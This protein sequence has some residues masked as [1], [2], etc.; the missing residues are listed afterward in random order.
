M[1]VLLDFG[2]LARLRAL[3]RKGEVSGGDEKEE[4]IEAAK[5]EA[6]WWREIYGNAAYFPL[7]VHWS[8]LDGWLGESW[9]GACGLAA[10]LLSLK[11]A[12]KETA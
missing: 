2:R 12:W 8:R 7:T 9:V 1:H 11:E 4:K 6:R 10:G 3:E 5:T